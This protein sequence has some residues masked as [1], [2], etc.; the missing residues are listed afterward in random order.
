ML[1]L[2]SAVGGSGAAC[3]RTIY[4][5]GNSVGVLAHWKVVCQ[6]TLNL[7]PGQDEAFRKAYG[8]TREEAALRE[9]D[10]LK[11]PSAFDSHCHID[12]IVSKLCRGKTPSRLSEVCDLSPIDPQFNVRLVGVVTVYCDPTRQPTEAGIKEWFDQGVRSVLGLH[13]KHMATASTSN[14]VTKRLRYLLS[15]PTVSGLGEVGLD[16]TSPPDEV[17]HQLKGLDKLL[18]LAV[19]SKVLVL[20]CRG[21]DRTLPVGAAIHILK[22]KMLRHVAREQLIHFHCFTG[23]GEH[24]VEW[25]RSFPNTYFGFTVLAARNRDGFLAVPQCRVLLETDAPYMELPPY[26]GKVLRETTP[27]HIG[28]VASMLAPVRDMAWE[29][30]LRISAENAARLYVQYLPPVQPY[31]EDQSSAS[32]S[33][34]P[35]SQ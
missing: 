22:D 14:K 10:L 8:I 30:L 1:E 19:P 2:A 28:M 33:G 23:S 34:I 26:E 15:R 16:F 24:V 17:E 5:S 9:S 18:P 25:L 6:L 3:N 4:T 31:G 11:L 35:G 27:A 29:E 21:N 7:L 12:R 20:H 32:G 13:P